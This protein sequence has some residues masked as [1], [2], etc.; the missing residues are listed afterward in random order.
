MKKILRLAVF[1]LVALSSCKKD[2]PLPETTHPVCPQTHPTSTAKTPAIVTTQHLEFPGPFDL[3]NQCTGE[4][5][6]VT[7]TITDDTHT[8]VNGSTANL[9]D[10]V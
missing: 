4:T 6:T 5:V 8:V 1:V 9:S 2:A 10:H 3:V 7:G